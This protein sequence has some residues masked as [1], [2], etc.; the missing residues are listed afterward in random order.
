MCKCKRDIHGQCKHVAATIFALNNYKNK[1][2]TSGKQQW[3]IQQ[4]KIYTSGGC[5]LSNC[6][7]PKRI[8]IPASLSY[9]KTYLTRKQSRCPDW[10]IYKGYRLSSSMAHSI[11]TTKSNFEKL[12]FRFLNNTVK[13]TI[14]TDYGI[15]L[16]KIAKNLFLLKNI[17]IID[18]GV[19]ICNEAP[20]I[21]ASPDGI[22]KNGDKISLL[23]IKYPYTC[24]DK[25]LLISRQIRCE[26]S[27]SLGSF[28]GLKHF[29]S[30]FPSFLQFCKQ[31]DKQN[32]ILKVEK[33][34]TFICS[35]LEK[36]Q[37]FYFLQL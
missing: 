25:N 11:K 1:S 28:K 35:L 8:K 16:E 13:E 17:R 29:S 6:V 32:V 27:D 12:D 31:N 33:D 30:L 21:C 19:I 24:K 23:K 22:C 3:G 9:Q 10:F 2:V 15:K 7:I 26:D 34:E 36:M 37:M 5:H 14:A 20:W 18:V 4:H